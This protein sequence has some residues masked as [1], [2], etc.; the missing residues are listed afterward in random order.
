[1]QALKMPAMG[2]NTPIILCK[3]LAIV[4]ATTYITTQYNALQSLLAVSHAIR[5][6]SDLNR[7]TLSP[8]LQDL[9]HKKEDARSGRPH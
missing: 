6:K 1:M 9:A 8:P 7:P 3:A 5:H 2:Y 4:K